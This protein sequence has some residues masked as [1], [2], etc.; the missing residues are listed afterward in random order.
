[1]LV[2]TRSGRNT[3]DR[4]KKRADEKIQCSPMRYYVVLVLVASVK[5]YFLYIVEVNIVAPTK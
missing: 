2:Y 3:A 4:L 5:V 1:M